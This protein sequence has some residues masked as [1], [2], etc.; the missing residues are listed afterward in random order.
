MGGGGAGAT[1]TPEADDALTVRLRFFQLGLMLKGATLEEMERLRFSVRGLRLRV[2]VEWNSGGDLVVVV[3]EERRRSDG[4]AV[5]AMEAMGG[6]ADA[7]AGA[8]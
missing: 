2:E 5:R 8:T 4:R 7:D 1:E 6:G 3:V